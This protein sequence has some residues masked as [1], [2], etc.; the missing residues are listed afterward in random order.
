MS[1]KI[2]PK[3]WLNFFAN[4]I[5]F[6]KNIIISVCNRRTLRTISSF[7]AWT[8]YWFAIVSHTN[9]ASWQIFRL[10]EGGALKESASDA[11]S[12]EDSEA[13]ESSASKVV[14]LYVRWI[15]TVV[16]SLYKHFNPIFRSQLP[17]S[18][19]GN[20]KG[21]TTV[22]STTGVSITSAISLSDNA[23]LFSFLAKNVMKS[24]PPVISSLSLNLRN[25]KMGY[26]ISNKSR[27]IPTVGEVHILQRISRF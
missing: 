4:V 25:G 22:I 20:N 18:C 6:G 13:V 1:G 27:N 17:S 14:K 15:E 9:F 23:E 26:Y 11:E 3:N 2:K 16:N 7:F 24:S 19:G 5:C 21:I 10:F 12:D 8:K